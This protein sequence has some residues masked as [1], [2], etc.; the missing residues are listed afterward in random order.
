VGLSSA[1]EDKRHSSAGT[2]HGQ[3]QAMHPH[4]TLNP[5]DG[6]LEK[7]YRYCRDNE[8]KHGQLKKDNS[9]T[10]HMTLKLLVS[11]VV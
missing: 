3:T 1:I 10:E 7:K 4:L 5:T 9:Q 2:P 8:A 6:I 11:S